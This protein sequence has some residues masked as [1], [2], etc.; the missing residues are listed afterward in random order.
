[1]AD[2][3]DVIVKMENEEFFVFFSDNTVSFTKDRQGN[4]KVIERLGAALKWLTETNTS[5]TE[6]D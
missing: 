3:I 4:A 2:K 1:M 6:Y 5:S